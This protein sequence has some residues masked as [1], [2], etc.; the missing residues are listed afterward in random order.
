MNW[1]CG[2]SADFTKVTVLMKK[3]AIY[4]TNQVSMASSKQAAAVSR[5][6]A[7][8][9]LDE[10]TKFYE[11]TEIKLKRNYSDGSLQLGFSKRDFEVS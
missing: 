6:F 7:L 4:S 1:R 2:L 10:I 9:S 8:K 5:R 3:E 11:E